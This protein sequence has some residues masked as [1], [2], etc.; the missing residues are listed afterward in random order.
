MRVKANKGTKGL[1]EELRGL[2]K[3]IKTKP[4]KLATVVNRI[5]D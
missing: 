1:Q 2:R 5:Q 3:G 4:R